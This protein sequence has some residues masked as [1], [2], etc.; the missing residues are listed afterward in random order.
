[1][2]GSQDATRR[3]GAWRKAYRL[4]VAV[5]DEIEWP[6]TEETL[7][8]PVA[9]ENIVKLVGAVD[10]QW[11]LLIY[12]AVSTGCR[13]GEL[14]RLNWTDLDL[15]RGGRAARKTKPKRTGSPTRTTT[16]A[17]FF[18]RCTRIVGSWARSM[19]RSLSG[20]TAGHRGPVDSGV[21]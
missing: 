8:T 2:Q 11:E 14:L 4:P 12:M 5:F 15:D 16:P 20:P 21:S 9:D 19:P 1:M 3:P 18:T 10:E 7:S 17:G 13:P 6:E